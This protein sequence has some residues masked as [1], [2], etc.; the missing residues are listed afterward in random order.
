M[1]MNNPLENLRQLTEAVRMAGADIAPT[2][3]EYVRFRHRKRLRGS[4][5]Q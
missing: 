1:N 4:G 3:I 2:Y 5:T